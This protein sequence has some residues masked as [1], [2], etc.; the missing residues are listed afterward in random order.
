[1]TVFIASKDPVARKLRL[2]RR[3]GKDDSEK[4]LA[5]LKDVAKEKDSVEKEHQ[6]EE[7]MKKLR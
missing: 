3:R 4:V 2:R 5:G 6:E 7:E 1:V